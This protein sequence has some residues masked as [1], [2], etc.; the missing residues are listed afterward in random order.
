MFSLDHLFFLPTRRKTV[1]TRC[2]KNC[3]AI[4]LVARYCFAVE[5]FYE[6]FPFRFREIILSQ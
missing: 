5:I 4:F 1:K 3:E 2:Q 6:S